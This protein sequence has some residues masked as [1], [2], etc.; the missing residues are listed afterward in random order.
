MTLFSL[1]RKGKKR[2]GKLVNI[3]MPFGRYNIYKIQHLDDG[4]VVSAALHELVKGMPDCP[5]LS[6]LLNY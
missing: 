1:V 2:K 3:V 4:S 6:Q 5:D